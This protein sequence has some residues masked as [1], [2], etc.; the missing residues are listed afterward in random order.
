[1]TRSENRTKIMLKD[2][3]FIVAAVAVLGVLVILMIGIGGFARGGDFNR[4]HAN[5]IMRYRIYAQA[6]AIALILLYVTLRKYMGQ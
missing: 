1:M 2:P 5:R 3:L 6:A 4:K